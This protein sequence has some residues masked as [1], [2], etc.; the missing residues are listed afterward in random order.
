MEFMNPHTQ[1]HLIPGTVD[2]LDADC[3]GV[4]PAAAT[5]VG[6]A[7]DDTLFGVFAAMLLVVPWVIVAQAAWPA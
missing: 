7:L 4:G 1:L 6:R 3:H 2:D 5:T